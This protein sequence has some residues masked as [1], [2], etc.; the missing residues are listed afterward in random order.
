MYPGLVVDD[1]AVVYGAAGERHQRQAGGGAVVEG[2]PL[3]RGGRGV[4]QRDRVSAR[5]RAPPRHAQ[6]RAPRRGRRARRRAAQRHHAPDTTTYNI[7]T[8]TE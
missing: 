5:R 4:A 7:H 1:P 2:G 6:P 3:Q 8:E